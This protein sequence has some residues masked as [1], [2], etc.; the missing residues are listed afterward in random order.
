MIF[1]AQWCGNVPPAAVV[2][3]LVSDRTIKLM[4]LFY[5]IYTNEVAFYWKNKKETDIVLRTKEDLFAVE[6]KYQ[7]NI[8][9]EDF[10]SLHHFKEG[11]IASKAT[12]KIGDKYSVVPIHILLALI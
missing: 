2:L 11:I 3:V 8:S 7:K 6:V 12:L 5:Y 9:K 4:Q 1:Y 10:G